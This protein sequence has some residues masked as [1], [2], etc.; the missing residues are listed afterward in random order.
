M[1]IRKEDRGK[2]PPDIILKAGRAVKIR[3]LFIRVALR[4]NMNYR[5]LIIAKDPKHVT[6]NL[7]TCNSQPRV[8]D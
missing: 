3:N 8:R 7:R 1:K 4:F 5:A 6:I 2:I